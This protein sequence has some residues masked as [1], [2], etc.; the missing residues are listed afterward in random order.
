MGGIEMVAGFLPLPAGLAFKEYGA[1]VAL[2]ISTSSAEFC[3]FE[4]AK[5]NTHNSPWF[6]ACWIHTWRLEGPLSTR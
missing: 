6:V 5:H 3:K 2:A 1:K 4:T